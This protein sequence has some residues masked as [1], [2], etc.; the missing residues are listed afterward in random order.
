MRAA[1]DDDERL[2]R[3]LALALDGAGDELLADARLA[4]DQHGDVGGGGAL[5]ERDHAL[6]AVAANDEVVEG[7]RAFDLLLDAADLVGER[8]DLQRALD[9]HLEALGRGGLDHEIDGARAHGVDGGVDRAVRGLHD[10]GGQPRLA[11]ELVEHGHAV[12]P[13]HDQVEQ[14]EAD[15]GALGP[16]EDLQGL[17]AGAG[18]F[19]VEAEPLDGFFKNAALGGI[20]VDD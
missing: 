9:R 1:V 6:H 19:G 20:V 14:N 3:A 13:V 11:V 10:D 8:L 4:F 5:A 18:A 15:F 16:F 17:L 7:E 2:A 12:D